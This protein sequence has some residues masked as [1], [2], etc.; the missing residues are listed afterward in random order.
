MTHASST[1]GSCA[2]TFFSRFNVASA[3]APSASRAAV[4]RLKISILSFGSG[5]TVPAF[6]GRS[7]RR[8]GLLDTNPRQLGGHPVGNLPLLA[9]QIPLLARIALEV[10]QLR[11]RGGDVL[12]SARTQRLQI[13]PAE[14]ILRVQR[15]AVGF[16]VQ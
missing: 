9:E 12:E 10:V 1:L 8:A 3:S 7:R 6:S 13:A 14:V 15:F 11:T 5:S 16:Q 2:T 4:I